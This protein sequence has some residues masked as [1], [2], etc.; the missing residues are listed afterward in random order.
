M[1]SHCLCNG[2]FRGGKELSFN[3]NILY[4]V[5]VVASLF[6]SLSCKERGQR[7]TSIHSG[8]PEIKLAKEG[9]AEGDRSGSSRIEISPLSLVDAEKKLDQVDG[10]FYYDAGR[11][12]VI[13]APKDQPQ[14]SLAGVKFGSMD[15][16]AAKTGR[17]WSP[18]VKP[19]KSSLKT[20]GLGVNS[21]S[22]TSVIDANKV[23]EFGSS[24]RAKSEDDFYYSGRL[25]SDLEGLEFDV[26]RAEVR[27]ILHKQII[28]QQFLP[29]S[30]EK[31]NKY[32]K[33]LDDFDGEHDFKVKFSDDKLSKAESDLKNLPRQS[34]VELLNARKFESGTEEYQ[35]AMSKVKEINEQVSN[36]KKYLDEY[37]ELVDV[38]KEIEEDVK[39][40][41][42][43][44][45]RYTDDYGEAVDKNLYIDFLKIEKLPVEN[46]KTYTVVL[47]DS[48]RVF[49]PKSG[50]RDSALDYIAGVI[51]DNQSRF[52]YEYEFEAV[53][54]KVQDWTVT[55]TS[56]KEVNIND[57]EV[58]RDTLMFTF[59]VPN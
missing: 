7:D 12:S 43:K 54:V 5:G 58:D 45:D 6:L 19:L 13:F 34:T 52:G 31:L 50:G 59:T 2:V 30:T 57:L 51:E 56:T 26:V 44:V 20:S 40:Y 49:H 21:K 4:V 17:T 3:L 23:D 42:A 38:R 28:N 35:S 55:N 16:P 53:P 47:G 8:Q 46:G 10:V 18:D 15:A 32:S 29:Q 48:A 24:G 11:G 25:E 41:Q 27:D 1:S 9:A 22:P 14:L 37:D 39:Y 33:R 36:T